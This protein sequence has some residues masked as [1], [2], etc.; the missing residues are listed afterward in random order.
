MCEAMPRRASRG[1]TPLASVERRPREYV[2]TNFEQNQSRNMTLASRYLHWWDWDLPGFR[3]ALA[4]L[5]RLR[6]RGVVKELGLTNVD[7]KARRGLFTRL[8][9]GPF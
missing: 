6:A 8:L 5:E 7:A 1:D 9:L 2:S 4:A 3:K